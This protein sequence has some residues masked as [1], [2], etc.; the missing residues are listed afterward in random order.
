MLVRNDYDKIATAKINHDLSM[1]IK[2]NNL[3]LHAEIKREK[4]CL[5]QKKW[6]KLVI[7]RG[8]WKMIITSA[9]SREK[10]QRI[11]NCFVE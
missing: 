7:L 5:N 2:I 11:V 10:R 6:I 3:V 1:K 8:H 4:N 9:A